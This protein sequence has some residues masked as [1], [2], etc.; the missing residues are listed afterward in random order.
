MIA[1]FLAVASQECL[2]FAGKKAVKGGE[3]DF[4][5]IHGRDGI[6]RGFR[7]TD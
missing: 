4:H 3:H 5:F 6:P 7:Q 2:L 1:P